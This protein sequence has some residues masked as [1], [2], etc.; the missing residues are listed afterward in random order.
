MLYLWLSVLSLPPLSVLSSELILVTDSSTRV[1][2]S[3]LLTDN[4]PSLN[5]RKV[6]NN[7]SNRP[8]SIEYVS[9]YQLSTVA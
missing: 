3:A 5:V 8:I 2:I 4:L 6:E 7:N 9:Y 1:T